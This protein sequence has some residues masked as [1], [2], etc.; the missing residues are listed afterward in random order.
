MSE[1][2]GH[3]QLPPLAETA[4][5]ATVQVQSVLQIT[6]TMDTQPALELP[7]LRNAHGPTKK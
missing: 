3:Q 7:L 5:L 2:K 1:D 4:I 6:M